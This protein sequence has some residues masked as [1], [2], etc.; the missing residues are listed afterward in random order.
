CSRSLELAMLLASALLDAPVPQKLVAKARSNLAVR[1]LA[2]KAQRRMLSSAPT[3]ELREFLNG[4]NTHDRLRHRLWP[5][6]TLLTTRT[7]GDYNA[8]ALPKSLWSM[9]YV[10][11]PFR[12]AAKATE[13]IVRRKLKTSLDG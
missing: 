4:L 11:R 7:V 6:A 1:A 10:T 2:D 13:L 12:L 8:M 5:I 3:G 9:Y